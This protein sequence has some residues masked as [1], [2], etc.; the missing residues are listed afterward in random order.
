MISYLIHICLFYLVIR[1]IFEPKYYT[2]YP[3]HY[4]EL[5]KFLYNK[6][7]KLLKNF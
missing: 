3:E 2:E 7:K 5:G 1:C 4:Y 6:D